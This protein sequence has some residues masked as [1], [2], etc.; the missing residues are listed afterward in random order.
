MRRKDR[1]ITDQTRIQAI[2]DRCDHMVLTMEDG[3]FPYAVPLSFGYQ[4]IGDQYILYFHCAQEGKKMELLKKNKKVGLCLA[5][6]EAILTADTAC[7]YSAHFESIIA[8]GEVTFLT[9]LEEKKEALSYLI[10]QY[11]ENA[12]IT[13]QDAVVEK[14]AVAAI[15]LLSYE[16]KANF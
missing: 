12:S 5:R 3:D 14:T 8:T 9:K 16:A 4:K 15:K 11:N 6:T 2:F 10:Q 7:K 13:F 1:A